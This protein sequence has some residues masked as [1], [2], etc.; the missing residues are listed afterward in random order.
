MAAKTKPLDK[1]PEPASTPQ[2]ATPVQAR[3]SVETVLKAITTAKQQRDALKAMKASV[4]AL[5]DKYSA[6]K[7]GY[8]QAVNAQAA[9]ETEL[10]AKYPDVAGILGEA[11]PKR[12]RRVVGAK[13]PKKA[14]AQLLTKDEAEKVLAA[15]GSPFELATF[16]TKVRELFPDKSGKGAI[17]L[18]GGKVKSAGGKGMGRKFKKT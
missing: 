12:K 18:L 14:S 10:L 4:D 5:K 16:V 3:D 11:A 6:A 2:A 8:D 1:T 15:L 17:K 9:K 13:K 7:D